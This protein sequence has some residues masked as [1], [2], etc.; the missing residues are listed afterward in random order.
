MKKRADW[1]Q[2]IGQTIIGAVNPEVLCPI[3][4]SGI[5][6]IVTTPL[7][8]LFERH[9]F[10]QISRWVRADV[11]SSWYR[12]RTAPCRSWASDYCVA[13]IVNRAQCGRLK[14]ILKV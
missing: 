3:N 13:R 6:S 14:N 9:L 12:C 8:H 4:S 7:Q 2:I 1:R 11:L 5:G 10:L